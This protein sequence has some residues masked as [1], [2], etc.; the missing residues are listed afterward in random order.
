M[1]KLLL[2]FV[3]FSC[4]LYSQDTI[5]NPL[6]DKLLIGGDIGFTFTASDYKDLG[7]GLMVRGVAEYYFMENGIHKLGV[8]GFGGYGVSSGSDNR[9]L[10]GSFTTHLYTLAGGGIYSLQISNSISP[11]LFLGL[12]Y[13]RFNPK[14]SDGNALPNNAAD[15]YDRNL[16]NVV[17]EFGMRYQLNNDLFMY[18]SLVPINLTNDNIDD[19]TS[20]S[21][22]DLVVALNVGL[23]YAL[24]APW[25][26]NSE[27]ANMKNLPTGVVEPEEEVEKIDEQDEVVD[28]VEN[29]EMESAIEVAPIDEK[30]E[31]NVDDS[32]ANVDEMD[33]GVSKSNIIEELSAKLDLG[34]VQF[35]FGKTEFGRMEYIELDRIARIITQD[36]KSKWAIAGYTDDKEPIQVHQSL[37]IQRAYFVLRYFMSKGI[38]RDRFEIVVKGEED[39]V[40]DNS[41]PEGRAKNRRV[42]VSRIK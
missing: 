4:I 8:R 5:Q 12:K 37:G 25:A 17:F 21:A 20:G 31:T 35:E 2:T 15:S 1:K 38:D 34:S 22:K 27:P 42:E 39:P 6:T 32:E 19:R 14:D 29:D 3:L 33:A 18:G 10:S 40:G 41:T 16:F 9:F 28:K 13:L 36:Q 23:L 24:D 26:K 7:V 11:Y 30:A